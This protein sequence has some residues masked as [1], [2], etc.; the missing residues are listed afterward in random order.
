MKM[1]WS[2]CN[3]RD[4]SQN[5]YDSIYQSL[6]PSRKEHI[7]RFLREDDRKRSLAGELI[8][9]KLLSGK[10]GITNA[11]IERLPNGRPVLNGANLFASISHCDDIVVCA[12]SEKEIGI[13]TERIKPIKLS[14]IKRFCV[15]EEKEYILRNVPY[16]E[17]L[18][19]CEDKEILN[20]FYEIW[21]AK[22]A[23]FKMLG[24]GIKDLKSVNVLNLKRTKFNINDY[25]IQIVFK[26]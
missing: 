22:E 24:T 23:Y 1:E 2:Y 7:D 5:D 12:V 6:T 11:L 21:T 4:L 20:R 25:L 19:Y 14:L 8:T 15:T 13:D 26:E 3:I 16:S 18:S 10:F 9:K 17:T